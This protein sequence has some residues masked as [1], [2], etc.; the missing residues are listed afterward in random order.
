MLASSARAA[1]LSSPDPCGNRRDNSQRRRTVGVGGLVPSSGRTQKVA[2][3]VQGERKVVGGNGAKAAS[4]HWRT[5]SV[6]DEGSVSRR[7]SSCTR[8]RG[9][10]VVWR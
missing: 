8:P 4:V 1:V 2:S 7:D 5:A 10:V 9:V 6:R 3:T